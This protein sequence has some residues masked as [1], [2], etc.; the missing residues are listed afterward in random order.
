MGVLES[1]A[2]TPNASCATWN[3]ISCKLI[4][5]DLYWYNIFAYLQPTRYSF[6]VYLEMI[7]FYIFVHFLKREVIILSFYNENLVVLDLQM[8][9]L[10]REKKKK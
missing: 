7:F 1:S 3:K 9:I 5:K 10:R 6:D 2:T 8:I 4:N